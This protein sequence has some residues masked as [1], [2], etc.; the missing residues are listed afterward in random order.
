MLEK[1]SPTSLKCFNAARQEARRLRS[2]DLNTRHLLLGLLQQQAE[3]MDGLLRPYSLSAAQV[4]EAIRND[5]PSDDHVASDKMVVS[6]DL[7]TALKQSVELAHDAPVTPSHLLLSLLDH[8]QTVRQLVQQLGVEPTKLSQA[9]RVVGVEPAAEPPTSTTEPTLSPSEGHPEQAAMTEPLTQPQVQHKPTPTLDSYSRDLTQLASEGQLYPMIGREREIAATIEILCRRMKR[10]PILVG[11]PGVGKTA[12][13]EGLAQRM[14]EGHVPVQLR[15]KRLVELSIS[16]LVAG[17]SQIGEFEK[18]LR[19][20]VNEVKA[21]GDVILFIDE[22]HTLLGAGGGY[23]LQDAATIL[24]PSLARGDIVC[25]GST[26]THEYRKYIEKD[27]AL[28]RRFQPVRVEEPNREDVL[29]ILQTLKPR[30]ESHFGVQ[31]P[32]HLLAE[33]F[34]LS[35]N[36]LKNRYFPDKAIDLLERAASRAMLTGGDKPVLTVETVL[37]VLSDIAGIP[38]EKLDQG[39]MERYLHMEDI[40]HQRVIGQD[41]AIESVSSL[42]RLTKRRL[43]LDPKRPDG[44]FLFVGPVGVGKTELAKALTEFLFG[45]EDRLIRLDMSE[46]SS[47][48]TVSR[49]IGSPP[50]YV[51]YDQGGQL[52]ERVERQPFCVLLLDEM[53]KAHQ[54]VLD[55]FLQIF[56]DGR[57]TDAQ[58]RTVYFAD[59]TI[60]MTSNLANDLWLHRRMGFGE[61]AEEEIHVTE[62]AVMDVLRRKLPNEFLSRIDE[63]VIFHPLSDAA[64]HQIARQK[65]NLIVEQR[66]MR[67]N[68]S[69]SFAPEVVE[70]VVSK[71][72]DVRFGCRRLER[73]IQKE[74]LE[75][76]AEQMY[77]SDWQNVRSLSVQ[78]VNGQVTFAKEALHGS[79]TDGH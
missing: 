46:F 30:F 3:W 65:L 56:D 38:L 53:E 27:G 29:R 52:T 45:D 7:K 21:A 22:A 28:A 48:F 50:G 37:S 43:D 47:E 41:Q 18:R 9:I 20:L 75:H 79:N 6:P 67:Q 42:I 14:V 32:E 33:T 66:F 1:L 57:L 76:L 51:G 8:D 78:M 34:E 13:A 61:G 36:Y 11:E 60:I 74:I 58:G 72:Y 73:V 55:L 17:A 59:A 71:G 25:I 40:L 35:K 5:L 54:S 62:E 77:R 70:Y 10:N 4:I 23:G 63:I 2:A 19:K 49:L 64:V 68:I 44:V 31:I 24:K 16:S 12:L 15:D 69:V 39:E 26:T